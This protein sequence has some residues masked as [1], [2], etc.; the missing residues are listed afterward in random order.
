MFT[1]EPDVAGAS[2]TEKEI[3]NFGEFALKFS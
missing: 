2:E 3:N 1:D